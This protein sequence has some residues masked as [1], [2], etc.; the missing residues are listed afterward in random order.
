MALGH[1]AFTSPQADSEPTQFFRVVLKSEV[2]LLA[3][4]GDGMRKSHWDASATYLP[5]RGEGI[6][7]RHF[8]ATSTTTSD[9]T[10]A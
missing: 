1:P 7:V 8:A 6:M 4:R 3:A 2:A 10:S 9:T 5:N